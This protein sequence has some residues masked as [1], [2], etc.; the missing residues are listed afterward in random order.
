MDRDGT[1]LSY[2]GADSV[3]RYYVRTALGPGLDHAHGRC[4]S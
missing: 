3:R 1:L 2:L 4:R